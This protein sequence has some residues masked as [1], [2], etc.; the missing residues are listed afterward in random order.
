MVMFFCAKWRSETE[1]LTVLFDS[2][3]AYFRMLAPISRVGSNLVWD[4]CMV[5]RLRVGW[6]R[7]GFSKRPSIT[8]LL[9]VE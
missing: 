6:L 8:Q 4:L 5:E 3:L 2:L 9:F 1:Y 7:V